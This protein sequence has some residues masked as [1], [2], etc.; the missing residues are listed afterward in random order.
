M[1][2][3]SPDSADKSSATKVVQVQALVASFIT[4]V[5]GM[6]EIRDT[7]GAT[8]EVSVPF[9]THKPAHSTRLFPFSRYLDMF[10][11]KD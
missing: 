3:D 6:L 4:S 1:I 2:P 9:D 10:V 7:S 5:L 11:Y 8:E